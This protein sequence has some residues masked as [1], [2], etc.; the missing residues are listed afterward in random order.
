MV[1]RAS[2]VIGNGDVTRTSRIA[3]IDIKRNGSLNLF[4]RLFNDKRYRTVDTRIA[5]LRIEP[6]T[7]V[8]A[9]AI[10][11]REN[12]FI[13]SQNRIDYYSNIV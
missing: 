6:G 2:L 12:F 8:L 7:S 10:T 11:A 3:L 1:E 4:D 9:R 5:N 13:D